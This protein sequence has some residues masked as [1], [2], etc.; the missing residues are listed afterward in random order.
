MLNMD[1]FYREHMVLYLIEIPLKVFD[2][3]N[4]NH[5]DNSKYNMNKVYLL[6]HIT[7]F[8]RITRSCNVLKPKVFGVGSNTPM[9]L[10]IH[11]FA[12]GKSKDG[13]ES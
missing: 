7:T 9:E 2:N 5:K 6:F 1:G 4:F 13:L 10:S 11:V 12:T 8:V 3:F